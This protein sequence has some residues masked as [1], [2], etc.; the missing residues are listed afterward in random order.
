MTEPKDT[1]ERAESVQIDQA[2]LSFQ[3]NNSELLA[4]HREAPQRAE[5]RQLRP[6]DRKQEKQAELCVVHWHP[7]RANRQ[8]ILHAH[9]CHQEMEKT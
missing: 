5:G 9:A 6:E 4:D 8:V 7:Q 1:G 3:R 2:V